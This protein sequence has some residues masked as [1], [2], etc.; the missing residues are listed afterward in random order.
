MILF[1]LMAL[2]QNIIDDYSSIEC[3]PDEFLFSAELQALYLA[4]ERVETADDDGRKFIL[5]SSRCLSAF[6]G[7]AIMAV[8]GISITLAFFSH[9]A[10]GCEDPLV[11]RDISHLSAKK[12]ELNAV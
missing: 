9:D 1:S 8:R 4:L 10:Y 6:L 2:F 12:K 11:Y 3:L 7:L 5:L